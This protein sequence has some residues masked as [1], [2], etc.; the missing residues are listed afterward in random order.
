MIR[1]NK[2]KLKNPTEAKRYRRRLN[3]RK[4]VSGTAERPRVVIFR[5]AKNISAQVIDDV[6]GK[7]LASVQSFGKNGV[8]A[9]ANKEGAEKVGKAL[10]DKLSAANINNV[11]FDRAGY[12]YHGVVKS[13][14]D[15]LRE[16]GIQL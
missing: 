15:T 10:A 6:A 3:I 5:S 7:T 8:E 9:K 12:K 1:K 2:R 11:V 4:T 14:A 13:F 16:S